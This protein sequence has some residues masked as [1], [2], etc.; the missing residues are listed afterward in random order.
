MTIGSSEEAAELA[1]KV[2]QQR[3]AAW[4]NIIPGVQSVYS[5]EGEIH[6]DP[7]LIMMI[8]TQTKLLEELT[9]YVK[10]EHPYDVPEVI[11]TPIFPGNEDYFS[12]IIEN[13]KNN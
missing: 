4:V 12:W 9:E 3:L 13:T 5:W 6:K 11:A 7:E 2:V 10:R 1:S 8:K